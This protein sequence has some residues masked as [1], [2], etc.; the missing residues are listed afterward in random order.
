MGMSLESWVHVCE[1]LDLKLSPAS[2]LTVGL[3]FSA[4]PVTCRQNPLYAKSCFVFCPVCHRNR[5]CPPAKTSSWLAHGLRVLLFNPPISSLR[6]GFDRIGV[7]N[8]ALYALLV[9][10]P[11]LAFADNLSAPPNIFLSTAL[12]YA[13]PSALPASV[14][15]L[16]VYLPLSFALMKTA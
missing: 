10:V 1:M 14:P 6:S 12:T 7:S 15:V 5:P 2:A 3:A 11:R 9:L 8:V 16:M 4:K 13:L